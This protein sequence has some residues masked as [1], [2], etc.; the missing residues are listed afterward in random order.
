ML[1]VH[2]EDCGIM[3]DSP[4]LIALYKQKL[5]DCHALTKLGPVNWP[6]GIKVTHD[7]EAQT[8]SLSQTAFVESILAQFSLTD[9]KAH[10][11][12]MIPA[13]IYSKDDSPKNQ[14]D[15]ARICKVPY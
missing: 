6:L 2:V 11:T 15:A 7:W 4:K 13:V 12:L 1:V 14:V 3:G 9:A 8:I 10:A 5:N